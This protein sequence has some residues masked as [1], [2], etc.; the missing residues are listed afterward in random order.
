M[1]RP[2]ICVY[3]AS[4]QDSFGAAWA[5]WNR[6]GDD[7]VQYVPMF[8]GE[9]LNADVT[10]RQVLFVGLSLSAAE[11]RAL[12]ANSVVVFHPPTAQKG[13]EPFYPKDD[14]RPITFEN[15]DTVLIKVASWKNGTIVVIPPSRKESVC[16]QAWEFFH[17]IQGLP[18]I[19][20]HIEDHELARFVFKG[21]REAT[22][23]LASHQITFA[24]LTWAEENI[25]ELLDQGGHILRAQEKAA[26]DLCRRA[27]TAYIDGCPVPCVNA[28]PFMASVVAQVLLQRHSEAAFVAT[29]HVANGHRH[30]SIHSEDRR[31]DV[32]AVARRHGGGGHRNAATFSV[33]EGLDSSEGLKAAVYEALKQMQTALDLFEDRVI[34]APR[35]GE[36]R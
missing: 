9:P 27:E 28:P 24:N 21:T 1:W 6:W 32:A 18:R 33:P 29:Y 35:E 16:R 12:P 23:A 5:V 8:P 14:Q 4:Q 2:D 19:L 3:E 31:S 10:D 7:S 15:I 30:Y 17:P 34:T 13:L 25:S 22:A 11:L 36:G 26:A 20:L